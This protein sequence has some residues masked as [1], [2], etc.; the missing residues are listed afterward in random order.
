MLKALRI[1]VLPLCISSV[2][3]GCGSSETSL[4]KEEEKNFKGSEMP[5]DVRAKLQQGAAGSPPAPTSEQ[6]K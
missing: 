3:V 4:S 1:L 5:A 2:L 6:S